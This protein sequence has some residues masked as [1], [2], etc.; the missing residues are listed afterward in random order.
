MY[1]VINV[2]IRSNCMKNNNYG[3]LAK[4]Y[5]VAILKQH[6]DIEAFDH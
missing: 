6:S 4:Q 5:N 3:H 1:G 2:I